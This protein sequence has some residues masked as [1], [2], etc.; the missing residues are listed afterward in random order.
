VDRVVERA[1]A[2]AVARYFAGRA[3]SA[4]PALIDGRLGLLVSP[5]GIAVSLTVTGG[6]IT[7]VDAVTDPAVFERLAV[8]PL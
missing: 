5:P 2:E 8:A 1:G 7:A 4:R 3:Q 6:R